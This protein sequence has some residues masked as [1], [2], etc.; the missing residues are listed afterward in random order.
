LD[1]DVLRL[2]HSNESI[3]SRVTLI[4]GNR[5]KLN[6]LIGLW[7][8]QGFLDASNVLVHSSSNCVLFSTEKNDLSGE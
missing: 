6:W 8:K 5:R 1:V 3:T 2:E 7:Q 4:R